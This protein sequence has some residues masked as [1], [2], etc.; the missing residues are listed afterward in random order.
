MEDN[1]LPPQGH[2]AEQAAG[3]HQVEQP[4]QNASSEALA[5]GRKYSPDALAGLFAIS[6]RWIET[7]STTTDAQ[8]DWL[9]ASIKL[10]RKAKLCEFLVKPWTAEEIR[11]GHEK[12]PCRATGFR[13]GLCRRH[14]KMKLPKK[15]KGS[16]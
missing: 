13:N 3:S 14:H 5:R 8:R 10:A 12:V 6:R 4:E 1:T 7:P 16:R 15:S 11:A 9:K 2:T